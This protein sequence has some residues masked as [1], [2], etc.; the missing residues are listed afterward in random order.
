MIYRISFTLICA[1]VLVAGVTFSSEAVLSNIANLRI[2]TAN[3]LAALAV[4]DWKD[5]ISGGECSGS[6]TDSENCSNKYITKYV[7]PGIP[8]KVISCK[9]HPKVV[10]QYCIGETQQQSEHLQY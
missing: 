1:G 2:N 5:D 4:A 7:F 9:I 8:A 3:A 6:K 10:Q